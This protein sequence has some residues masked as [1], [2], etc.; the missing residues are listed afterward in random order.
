MPLASAR[1]S[2]CHDPDGPAPGAGD[3]EALH[4]LVVAADDAERA[5]L[6]SLIGAAPGM[7]STGNSGHGGHAHE[8]AR[9]DVLLLH[10]D[11]HAPGMERRLREA[12]AAWHPAPVLVLSESADGV[13]NREFVR[14]GARGVVPKALERDQL[15]AA[16]RRVKD[17]EIWL[18]RG[19][20]SVIIDEMAAAKASDPPSP[21]RDPFAALTERER[22]VVSHIAEGLHNRAIAGRLG[23]TENTV[24]HHLT[25]IYGKLG[26]AD[27]L[28][29][30]VCALR[31][32]PGG[33]GRN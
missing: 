4:V 27:R 6:R 26:V 31:H 24:R 18:S 33:R 30:A 20:L 23:I 10:L 3:G 32:R 8:R 13:V 16:I 21:P 11:P 29:L 12:I 17:G 22:E 1:E 19:C 2:N 15:V 25:A 28:E 5:R 7:C 14:R 9:P